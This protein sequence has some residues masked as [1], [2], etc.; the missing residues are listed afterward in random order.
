MLMLK[1]TPCDIDKK[2]HKLFKNQGYETYHNK[3]LGKSGV[4]LVLVYKDEKKTGGGVNNWISYVKQYAN[5][6]GITY[7][8]AL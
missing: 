3:P 8:Q 6:K 2:T 7:A 5:K 4:T 1:P